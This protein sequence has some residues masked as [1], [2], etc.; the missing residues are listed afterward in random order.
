MRGTPRS[1]APASQRSRRLL[2]GIGGLAALLAA[3]QLAVASPAGGMLVCALAAVGGLVLWLRSNRTAATA[4]LSTA[5]TMMWIPTVIEAIGKAAGV[6]ATVA[7]WEVVPLWALT[8]AATAGAWLPTRH[9]G[10]RAVTVVMCHLATAIAA[11]PAAVFPASAV[12]GAA[13]VTMGV[14][15]AR[16]GA[17]A[18]WRFRLRGLPGYAEQLTPVRDEQGRL[19]LAAER[20]DDDPSRY[21]IGAGGQIAAVHQLPRGR[22]TL[23]RVTTPSGPP[24]RAYALNGSPDELARTLQEFAADDR[25]LARKLSLDAAQVTTLVTAPHAGL[26][27]DTVR[28]D[29]AGIWDQAAHRYAD[30]PVTV[31]TLADATGYL[32]EVPVARPPRRWATKARA[33]VRAEH[34]QE[35]GDMRQRR[36][37]VAAGTY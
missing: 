27:E 2:L 20:E 30:H 23:E 26:T 17:P 33:A 19:W 15:I 36:V 11:L 1:T 16:S 13:T 32:H 9:R 35:L 10:S 14:L 12:A 37:A 21:Y 6:P 18:A 3:L 5:V 25:T 29:L 34:D 28:I 7:S 4:V 22:I 24:V 31:L 8:L